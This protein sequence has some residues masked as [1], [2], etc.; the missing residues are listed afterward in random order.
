MNK[1]SR[2]CVEYYNGTLD[3]IPRRRQ[4]RL[5]DVAVDGT[6]FRDD[7]LPPSA[8][9]SV[10]PTPTAALFDANAGVACDTTSQALRNCTLR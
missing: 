7:R 4:R 6:A 3:D 10:H 2:I 9:F 1:Q 5:D 8:G